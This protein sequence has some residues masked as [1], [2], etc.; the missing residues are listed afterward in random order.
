M[1]IPELGQFRLVGGTALAL[2]LG[3]RTSLDLDLFTSDAFDKNVIFDVLQKSFTDFSIAEPRSSR[4]LFANINGI[5][6][7]FVHI[8]EPFNSNFKTVNHIRLASLEEIAA[9]KLNAIAGRGAKKDFWDI[10]CLLKKFTFD[11]MLRFYNKKY[12]H[13][14]LMT[15]IKSINYFEDA[16]SNPDPFSFENIK[17]ES[18]KKELRVT[19]KNY[20]NK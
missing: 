16:E 7:D 13:N 9:F 14:D 2:L 6:T 17:W 3:H 19:L 18:I 20:L 15:V 4:L 1:Q 10:H 8:F 11:Q 12:P 5:K